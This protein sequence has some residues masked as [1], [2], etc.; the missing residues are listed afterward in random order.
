MEGG[1]AVA[2]PEFVDIGADR[3]D[4]AGDVVTLVDSWGGGV[5]PFWA[6]RVE[7]VRGSNVLVRGKGG[8]P[9]SLWGW[10]RIR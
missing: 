6:L 9:S 8:L 4:D 3:V 2:G 1:Y 5:R 10:N 7:N